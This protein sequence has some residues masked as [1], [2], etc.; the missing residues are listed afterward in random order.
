MKILFIDS[1]LSKSLAMMSGNGIIIEA[2]N[3]FI[4]LSGFLKTMKK[5]TSPIKKYIKLNI[6]IIPPLI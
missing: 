1:K 3:N 4:K 2:K 6:E 5:I